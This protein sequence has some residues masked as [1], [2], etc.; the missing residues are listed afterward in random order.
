MVGS[1]KELKM[2]ASVRALMQLLCDLI[3][4]EEFNNTL[5]ALELLDETA[6]SLPNA[7]TQ[8]ESNAGYFSFHYLFVVAFDIFLSFL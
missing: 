8:R 5:I 2:E 1:L 6:S 3:Q 7:S 4:R